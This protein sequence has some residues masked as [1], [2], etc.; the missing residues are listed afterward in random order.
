MVRRSIWRSKRFLSLPDDATRYLYLYFL[1]CPH[2]TS[3]GCFRLN[4]AYALADLAMTGS[5]WTPAKFMT[6]KA[7]IVG[8]GLI[9]A[10]EETDEILI[11]RWWQDNGP[12]NESW[13]TGAE[14]QC[15]A[16]ESAELKT[17]AQDALKACWESY[18]AA[19][20]PSAP[21]GGSQ[22]HGFPTAADKLAALR[23]RT[24]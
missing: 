24:G 14:K 21:R 10:D 7:A 23:N 15:D 1:T 6:A 13:F 18:H 20:L 19:R 12:N 9:L 22:P 11:T 17:A 4:E 3:S 5:D 8:S 2:Q 16:I